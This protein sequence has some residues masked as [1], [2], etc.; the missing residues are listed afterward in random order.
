M[1]K[2]TLQQ[3]LS[4]IQ[5][6]LVSTKK[7][8]SEHGN[9][10]YRKA[11]EIMADVKPYLDEFKVSITFDDS[12]N[13]YLDWSLEEKNAKTQTDTTI[14]GAFVYQAKAILTDGK[15]R[16]TANGFSQVAHKIAAMSVG[17]IW[18]ATMSYARKYALCALLLIDN[19]NDLDALKSEKLTK[20]EIEELCNAALMDLQLVKTKEEISEWGIKYAKVK[21]HPAVKDIAMN[22]YREISQ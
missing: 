11:E 7:N 18:G 19:E 13:Y 5:V 6:K 8:K 17:Q 14:H 21:A 4:I 9:Y 3:I 1:E 2:L 16:S 22:K 12:Y 15:D 10:A 20:E